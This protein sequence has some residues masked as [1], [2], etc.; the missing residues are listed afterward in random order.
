MSEVKF[1]IEPDELESLR[2]QDDVL[3][4]DLSSA[5]QY[6][7]GH[8]PEAHYL[9]YAHIVR[10][11]APVMGLL[12]EAAVFSRLLSNFGA[13]ANTYIIAYDDEGGGCAARLLW[14][15]HVFGHARASMLNGG[16]ISWIKEGHEISSLP[17]LNNPYHE[18]SLQL[19]R[20]ETIDAAQIMQQLDAPETL[21]LDA[22]SAAE[23]SGEKK[24]A[25]KAGHIP[26]AA[27]YEWTEAI[28]KHNNMRVLPEAQIQAR[29]AALDVSKEKNIICYCQSHHRSAYLWAVL[30]HMG[31][32]HVSGYPGSWSDWGNRTDTP[33]A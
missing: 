24:F 14:T 2:K 8:I 5:A 4:L 23:Y 27:H 10:T 16:I 32:Q 20:N 30:K 22:R 7:A 18:Y 31:Y 6:I 3:I 33:V 17:P 9:P 25:T 29:L 19:T 12:P 13:S 15:L 21:L 28:D 11:Q 26:G 1:I